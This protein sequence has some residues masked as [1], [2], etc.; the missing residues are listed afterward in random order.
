MSEE[1]ELKEFILDFDE[2]GVLESVARL[3]ESGKS[4]LEIMEIARGAMDDVGKMF[5]EKEIFLTELIMA[6]ELLN[7]IMEE[8]GLTDLDDDVS[9]S[10]GKILVG[11]V[12]DDIH[13]IG[14][15]ILKSLLI[16]NGYSVIDIGVDQP[17]KAF[18]E[19]AKQHAPKVIAM[20]GLL[21]IA[22]DSM[23]ATIDAFKA[24]GIRQDYKIIV[25]GGSTDQKVSEYVGADDFG[26]SAV[27][28]VEKISQWLS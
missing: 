21:T 23:K 13:D 1:N 26:A 7:I 8:I 6:G 28:G 22:Y 24:A 5:E 11:T 19:Q 15:N 2:E 18:I 12:K 16:S 17:A 25:G 27:A 14:K 3:Q 9:S 20:S 4:A 10:K